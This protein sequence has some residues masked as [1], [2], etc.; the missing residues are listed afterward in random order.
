MRVRQAVKI[1]R[2]SYVTRIQR[3]QLMPCKFY[4]I[5]CQIV[6][7]TASRLFIYH[8]HHHYHYYCQLYCQLILISLGIFQQIWL[9][10]MKYRE[11]KSEFFV[12]LFERMMA[13]TTTT[14]LVKSWRRN[15]V[16]AATHG[17]K[18]SADNIGPCVTAFNSLAS[19]EK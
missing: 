9:R 5:I 3:Y 17:P 2:L 8:P 18:S 16:K 13:M 19:S 10:E 4:C 15:C 1:A 12:R 11:M 14:T 7:F 6:S